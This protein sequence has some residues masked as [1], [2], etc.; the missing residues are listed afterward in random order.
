MS[1]GAK[2]TPRRASTN[3]VAM[4]RVA[5]IGR[6]PDITTGGPHFGLRPPSSLAS[7]NTKKRPEQLNAL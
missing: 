3:R 5:M 1:V 7:R 6:Q 4:N 2:I